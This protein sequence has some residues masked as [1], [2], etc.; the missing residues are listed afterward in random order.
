VGLRLRVGGLILAP[1]VIGVG[2]LPNAPSTAPYV[3]LFFF[4]SLM[5]IALTRAEEI[6]Q[7]SS[8]R[9]YS[10]RPR[11]IGT[12][13]LTSVLIVVVSG[14]VALALS[15]RGLQ[16]LSAWLRPLWSALLFFVTVL[17][18]T[19]TYFLLYI[20]TPLAWLLRPLLNLFGPVQLDP[21]P[22]PEAPPEAMDIDQLLSLLT[23]PEAGFIFWL[24][25]ALI[26]LVVAGTLLLVYLALP[27]NTWA[28]W[29]KCGL[30]ER[31][32]HN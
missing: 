12:I 18:T 11:W 14:I 10:M 2:M 30:R 21:L 16:Q 7:Q 26:V 4:A 29:P 27:T 3:L 13:F 17:V 9:G 25:R 28:P 23:R 22:E 1:F 8:G 19:V 5:A 15:G 31:L 32:K 6:A 20:L 24:N